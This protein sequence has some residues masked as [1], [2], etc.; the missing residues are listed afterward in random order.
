MEE[1]RK[2][3]NDVSMSAA[4]E[5]LKQLPRTPAAKPDAAAVQALAEMWGEE[6][7]TW[8]TKT[9]NAEGTQRQCHS[10]PCSAEFY[11]QPGGK[12]RHAP[13]GCKGFI[14]KR[15]FMQQSKKQSI[16]ISTL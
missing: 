4:A 9:V 1:A 7:Y 3:A 2:E 16:R 13:Q 11:T 12:I 15:D 6:A 14:K 8:I 5:E 10:V